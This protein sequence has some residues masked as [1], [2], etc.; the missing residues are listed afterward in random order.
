[1]FEL[2]FFMGALTRSRTFL[3]VPR[4]IDL[5][6]PT[7]LM[8]ITPITYRPELEPDTAA[9]VAGACNQLRKLILTI[10]PR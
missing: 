9:A 3:L 7:D 2:G 10:G 1:M 4:G 5:R 6:L 8:G